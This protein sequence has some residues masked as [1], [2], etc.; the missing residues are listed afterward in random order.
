[1]GQVGTVI[2]DI[3]WEGSQTDIPAGC[4]YRPDAR[5]CQDPTCYSSPNQPHFNKDTSLQTTRGRGD[6]APICRSFVPVKPASGPGIPTSDAI[7]TTSVYVS[8]SPTSSPSTST[9][10]Q[11]STSTP[12][13]S[14]TEQ[15][16]T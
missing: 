8:S 7:S 3:A 10:E 16:S 15:A 1:M 9:T 6:L 13:S 14:T 2:T 5:T 11:A 4:A 12:S